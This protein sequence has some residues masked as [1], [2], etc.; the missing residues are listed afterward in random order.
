MTSLPGKTDIFP[1]VALAFTLGFTAS[2]AAA[3]IKVHGATTVTFG[4]MRPHKESIEKKS[5]AELTILPS[6]TTRGL[7]DLAQG[8]ADIAMLAEPLETAAE[9]VN[10]K[11]P[12]S[13]KPED[14]VGKHVGNAYVQFIVHPS[15][16]VKK[17]S[18]SQLA[19]LFSG[20]IKNWSEIGGANQPVLLIGE[21]TSSPHKMIAAA[22]AI[23]YSPDL[24]VVQNTNQTAV[25]VVQAP[26]ALSYIT[27]A[28]D[29]PERSKLQVVDS[30][31]K[32]PLALYLA[33][34]KDAPAQVKKVVEA[35]ASVATK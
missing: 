15:N 3:D 7:T 22:L 4:L 13:I 6:S 30:E 20:K 33:Y 21:P 17:L 2:P 27:T 29:L 23:S 5:G 34:R 14:L 32:L 28:H 18:K 25:I 8:K 19:G 11:Q 26:G 12:G 16:P 10:A 24:R 9:S 1:A 31:V 35:A